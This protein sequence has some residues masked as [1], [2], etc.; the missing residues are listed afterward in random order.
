MKDKLVVIG[1]RK[2]AHHNLRED[3]RK[4]ENI[5]A[6]IVFGIHG[7]EDFGCEPLPRAQKVR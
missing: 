7:I 4:G 2:L 1:V 3:N 5:R 6:V